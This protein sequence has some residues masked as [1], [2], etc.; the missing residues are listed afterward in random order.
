[1]NG[2]CS[3]S[4]GERMRQD[5][6]LGLLEELGAEALGQRQNSSS[7]NL[8]LEAQ[9]RDAHRRFAA[10]FDLAKWVVES[11]LGWDFFMT[12]PSMH[13]KLPGQPGVNLPADV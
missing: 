13:G 10:S 2:A 9:E 4:F 6:A 11:P 1:M 12:Q 8:R 7:K 3:A 5:S